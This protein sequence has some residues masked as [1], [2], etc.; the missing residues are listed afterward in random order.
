MIYTCINAVSYRL[1]VNGDQSRLFL[2]KR[3]KREGDLFLV[4]HNRLSC[5]LMKVE[6]LKPNSWDQGQS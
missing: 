6:E 4:C 1:Q 3:G 2:P 5:V